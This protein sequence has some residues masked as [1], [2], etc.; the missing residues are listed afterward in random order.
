MKTIAEI[1]KALLLGFI[2]AMIL[3][4]MNGMK[5][6]APIY[7]EMKALRG[8]E[9]VIRRDTLVLQTYSPFSGNFELSNGTHLHGAIVEKFLI[10]T[11]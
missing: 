6:Y 2:V 9:V 4:F 1:L 10:E 7:D 3:G 8:K 11:K 5:E